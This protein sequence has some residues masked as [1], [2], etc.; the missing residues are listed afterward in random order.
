MGNNLVVLLY[1]SQGLTIKFLIFFIL[2][3]WFIFDN[4]RNPYNYQQTPGNSAGLASR[5]LF[6]NET[7]A[8]TGGPQRI[9]FLSNGFRVVANR[10]SFEPNMSTASG[11]RYIYAAFAAHPF[12]G[13]G[14]TPSTAV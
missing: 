6:P 4:S 7:D 14:L 11:S 10:D 12:G 13:S 8:G 3:N 1:V 2:I 5:I 9:D